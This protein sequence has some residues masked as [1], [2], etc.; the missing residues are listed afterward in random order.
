MLK[1][2]A[3]VSRDITRLDIRLLL[4]F[5]AL[6]AERSVTR[7]AEQAGL[8][9]QGM[10]GQLARLRDIFSDPLFVRGQGGLIATP[11]AEELVPLV[12]AALESLEALVSPA[13]FNP[14][15]FNGTV[16]IAATDYAAALVMPPLL[17]RVRAAAPGLKIIVRPAGIDALESDVREGAIDLALTVPQFVPPGLRSLHLF[18]ERYVGVARA[19]HP[20]LADGLVTLDGFC[21]YP[22]VLVSPFRGD[23]R[24][25]TDEALAAVGRSRTVGLVVPGFSVVGSLIERTDMVAV[26]PERLVG[27]WRREVRTFKLPVPV[28]GFAL[29]A[30]WPPRLDASPLHAWLCAEI[31]A[32]IN[33][34]PSARST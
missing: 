16:T 1:V 10:S 30:Y 32:A 26:L 2:I 31:E 6:A 22:H 25:P 17:D 34:T 18:E 23:A 4:A 11:R 3:T 13:V 20:V 29:C 8:T 14:A 33:A 9:Q 15:D 21:A 5:N 7:A 12:H 27:S 28:P 24:G 19:D